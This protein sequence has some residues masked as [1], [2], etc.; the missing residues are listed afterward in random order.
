MKFLLKIY[1]IWLI[2]NEKSKILYVLAK[3]QSMKI[4]HTISNLNTSSGGPSTSVYCLLKGLQQNEFK[5]DVLT[6]APKNATDVFIG[7]DEFI[8]VVPNDAK[9]S[10]IY[11]HN[12]RNYLKDNKEYNLYHANGLWTDPTHATVQYALKQN[13]PCIITPRGMLYPQALLVSHWKK[14]LT[15]SLFQYKDLKHAACLHATC[16]QEMQHFRN[17]GLLNPIAVV[18]NCLPIDVSVQP[19]TSENIVKQFGFVGRLNRIKNIEALLKAWLTLSNTTKDAKLAIVGSGDNAYEIE[20]QKYVVNHKIKN[21]SFTGFLSGEALYQKIRSL[22]YLV[23]PS[24]TENFGMVIPEALIKGVPVI[25]SKGTPWEELNTHNCGWWIDNDIDTLTETIKKA[26]NTPESIR[27]EMGKRGQE[28]VKNNYSIEVV[29]KKMIRL[30]EW[31]LHGG[32]KPEFV[33]Y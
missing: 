1:S 25:A 12:F 14:R 23:L 33:Y 18:P 9:T 15:L 26:I 17:F 6:I 31:I 22:D 30:Y 21:I 28:L 32:E 8:K 16:N 5:A 24:H 4:L 11:S 2:A 19:R 3:N 7:N 13:K 10:L 29:A 20:L 27:I